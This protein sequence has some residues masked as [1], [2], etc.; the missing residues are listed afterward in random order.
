LWIADTASEHAQ[1]GNTSS[2]NLRGILL[3]GATGMTVLR[4]TLTD[5]REIDA[6]DTLPNQ[7]TWIRNRCSTDD[8]GGA[9]CAKSPT[10]GTPAASPVTA[11]APVAPPVDSSHWPCLAV[12]T[13]DVDPIGG[14]A[15]ITISVVAPDAPAGTICGA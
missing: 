14:G 12:P 5:N 4:N 3:G 10:P 8:P 13:W 6:R 15:W 11:F 7:N 9:L 1:L 2:R